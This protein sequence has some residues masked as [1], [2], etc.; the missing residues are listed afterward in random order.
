MSCEFWTGVCIRGV[1][2]LGIKPTELYSKLNRSK[3]IELKSRRVV[4]KDQAIQK[5]Q[6]FELLDSD[7][8]IRFNSSYSIQFKLFVSIRAARF[9]RHRFERS[10]PVSIRISSR[11]E[12]S[13]I[14]T[15]LWRARY[16]FNTR[17]RCSRSISFDAS[18]VCADQA[19]VTV[20]RV[21]LYYVATSK[22][23]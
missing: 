1:Q 7:W 14:W 15:H 5:N 23:A 6:T 3:R 8:T 9:S 4:L 19:R 22:K 10:S 2:I 11:I 20:V 21:W 12:Y 18:S 17:A 13:S 16:S